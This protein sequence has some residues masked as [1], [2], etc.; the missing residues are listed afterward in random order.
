[1]KLVVIER[2]LVATEKLRLTRDL[3]TRTITWLHL[4]DLHI[5]QTPSNKFTQ[6]IVLDSL[7]KDIDQFLREKKL[8]LNLLF[9]TGDVVFHGE[10]KEYELARQFLDRLL[11]TAELQKDHL[12]II[13]GNH[14]VERSAIAPTAKVTKKSLVTEENL[15]D[16]FTNSDARKFMLRGLDNYGKFINTYFEK[17]MRF[18]YEHYYYSQ[19]LTVNGEQL[20][21]LGLNS[22]WSCYEDE[23]MGSALIGEPQVIE[24][25]NATK[26]AD[27]R[28]ALI[29]HPLEWLAPFDREKVERYLRMRCPFILHGHLH[30]EQFKFESTLEG[31]TVTIPCGASFI[32]RNYP[33]S[34]NF[35]NLDLNSQKGLRI[36]ENTMTDF[37]NG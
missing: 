13:P 25:I 9:L 21:V 6:D 15:V 31:S 23:K 33:N 37:R 10:K 3:S 26:E 12:F 22:A 29:H 18:D 20:A 11:E 27:L 28:I 7:L 32:S 1:M 30:H 17:S 24:A 4:S 14:D 36:S 2:N 16:L 34:Y 8:C 5:K 35:V 19:I